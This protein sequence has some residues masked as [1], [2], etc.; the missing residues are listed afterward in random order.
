M[1]EANDFKYS[2]KMRSEQAA[3]YLIKLAEGIRNGHLTL[4]AQGHTITIVPKDI[5]KLEVH[6]TSREGKGELEL[7]VSWREKYVLSAQRL[8]VETG[9]TNSAA[10]AADA[11]RASSG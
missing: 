1:A 8:D 4:Q 5:V 11:R 2:D 9:L 6:A 3:E 10:T 7:E